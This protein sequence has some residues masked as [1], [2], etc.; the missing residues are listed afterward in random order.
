MRSVTTIHLRKTPRPPVRW[1]ES[2]GRRAAMSICAAEI[3]SAYVAT[4]LRS[5]SGEPARRP[6]KGASVFHAARRHL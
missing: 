3:A 1:G 6:R 4:F 2:V 5:T